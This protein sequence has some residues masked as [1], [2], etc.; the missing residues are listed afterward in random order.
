[1]HK[2]LFKMIFKKFSRKMDKRYNLT[3]HGRNGNRSQLCNCK[4]MQI[5]ALKLTLKWQQ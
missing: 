2:K 1:M 3:I 5:T 4:E